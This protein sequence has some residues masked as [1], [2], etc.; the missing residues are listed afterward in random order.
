M[1]SL[2]S[3][4]KVSSL[5][6][7]RS[8][9]RPRSAPAAPTQP[10]L[11]K[12]PAEP[13][14]AV[15]HRL[16]YIAGL[17]GIRAVAVAVVVLYHLGISWMP[18]GFLGVEVFFVVSGYLICALLLGEMERTSTIS[19]KGFWLRRA[20]RLLPALAA[21]LVATAVFVALAFTDELDELWDQL[22]AAAL[23]FTNWL[24]IFQDQSYFAAFGRPEVLQ[25]L[26]SLAIEEQFYLLWPLLFWGGM[27][28]LGRTGFAVLVAA[29]VAASTAWMW[30]LF[31]P[32][33]DPSRIYYGT[34]SRAGGL[35]LGA[36][37][38]LVWRPWLW[39]S[40]ADG[41]GDS[42]PDGDAAPPTLRRLRLAANIAGPLA[43]AGIIWWCAW[44]SVLDEQLFKG[45]FLWLSATTAVLIA[46][47]AVPGTWFGRAM[48]NPVMRWLGVRS[49]AIYLWHWPVFVFTRPNFD[50]TISGWQ[51]HALRMV[52]TLVLS[53]LSY[54][55]V[56][57]PIRTRQIRAKFNSW[58][59]EVRHSWRS[60][61]TPLGTVASLMLVAALI[62][63]PQT[64]HT[65]PELDGD[66]FILELP[67]GDVAVS[68][69]APVRDSN[70]AAPADPGETDRPAD[71]SAPSN[72]NGPN[73]SQP[74]DSFG[75]PQLPGDNPI[76][77][78]NPNGAGTN[79]GGNP[80]SAGANGG[81]NPNGAGANADLPEAIFE[82]T[83]P[84]AAPGQSNPGLSNPGQSNPGLP[85]PTQF[86]PPPGQ[87]GDTQPQITAFGDSVMLGSR[88][89]LLRQFGDQ[90]IVDAEVSRQFL[91][92][93]KLIQQYR[94]DPQNPSLGEIVLI[95]LGTN[96][97]LNAKVF[98]D[99]MEQ[100]SDIERVLFVN[101][102]VPRV[103][104]SE[105][106]KQLADGVLRWDNAHLVDWYGYSQGQEQDWFNTRD[107]VHMVPAG[108]EA[109]AHLIQA[110]L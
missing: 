98:D 9:L 56:E 59:A 24:L 67:A 2:P 41:D 91:N 16:P 82:A 44:L 83:L 63:V 34:D 15:R 106:N 37:L 12:P 33:E 101:V 53:D 36:L 80:N 38:A 108:A 104:E 29:G 7:S 14:G 84:G 99:T 18:G 105:V 22:L 93:P 109:Y 54:R 19:L 60:Y 51:L 78:D 8:R 1:P 21:L 11:F 107:G 72:P 68:L 81:D 49:Y 66:N 52:A 40:V 28:L 64:S 10:P 46:A 62:V 6:R 26:W 20:R 4:S 73:A 27:R 31:E 32:L 5:L 89:Y 30:W 39:R 85:D 102:R 69:Q 76:G 87:W 3:L 58:L 90:I 47:I 75:L 74:D 17:D 92:L 94:Q 45:G 55:L 43:L 95:H 13:K 110:S 79:G 65:T 42:G 23:Y 97:Y 100:L 50:V 70:P 57:H 88:A 25:H 96:G 61:I 35:L 86:A 103:W 48:D 71:P 77:G